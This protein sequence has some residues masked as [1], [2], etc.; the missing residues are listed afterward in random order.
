MESDGQQAPK[1]GEKIKVRTCAEE[2]ERI[3]KQRIENCKRGTAAIVKNADEGWRNPWKKYLRVILAEHPE[4]H[5]RWIALWALRHRLPD[6]KDFRL[7]CIL[8]Y[9]AQI[10]EEDSLQK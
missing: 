7:R 9:L 6:L 10:R 4:K 5:P 2:R 1:G 3:R 8:D